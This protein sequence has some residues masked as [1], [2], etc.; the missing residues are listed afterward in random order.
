MSALLARELY[1][2]HSGL[3]ARVG[4][5]GKFTLGCARST[6]QEDCTMKCLTC[7]EQEPAAFGTV[8]SFVHTEMALLP[9][10]GG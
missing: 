7:P 2:K 9:K 10:N 1:Y 3:T 6:Q 8:V 5:K 4:A